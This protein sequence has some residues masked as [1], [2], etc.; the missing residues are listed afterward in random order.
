MRRRAPRREEPTTIIDAPLGLGHVVEPVGRR[1]GADH[2]V[3]RL[4]A[5]LLEEAPRRRR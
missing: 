5:A 2:A 1:A 3:L 4:H